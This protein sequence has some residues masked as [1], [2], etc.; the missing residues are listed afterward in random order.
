M[1]VESDKFTQAYPSE[2]GKYD[3]DPKNA[4]TVNP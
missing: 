1:K 2:L 4:P 3:C